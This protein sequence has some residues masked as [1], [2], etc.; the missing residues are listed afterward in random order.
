MEFK[1]IFLGRGW[2]LVGVNVFEI[3]RGVL[4][5]WGV[6]FCKG[7]F[8]W[9]VLMFFRG[10]MKLVLCKKNCRLESVVVVGMNCYWFEEELL[11]CVGSKRKLK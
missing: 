3:R 1:F 2:C 7:G 8:G 9:L 4:R 10:M 5:G 6:E 11:G